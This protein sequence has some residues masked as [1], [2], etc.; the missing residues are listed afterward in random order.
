MSSVEM[1]KLLAQTNLP[2]QAIE[3][4]RKRLTV[5][6]DLVKQHNSRVAQVKA[7]KAADANN[8]ENVDAAWKLNSESDAEIDE[9]EPRFQA[10]T[11]EY[12]KVLA[13][14]RERGKLQIKAPL[15]PEEVTKTRK[16]VNDSMPGLEKARTEAETMASIVTG[17]LPDDAPDI[18]SFIPAVESMKGAGSGGGRKS[19]TSEFLQ[20]MTRVGDILIDGVSTKRD[21][22]GKFN[23]AADELSKLFKVDQFPQNQVDPEALED[24]YYASLGIPSRKK[25]ELPASHTFDF[26]FNTVVGVKDNSTMTN[27]VT[28]KVTVIPPESKAKATETVSEEKKEEKEET[29]PEANAEK[30]EEAKPQDN[31]SN[32]A[33]NTEKATPAKKTAPKATK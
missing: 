16:V 11:A 18:M 8:M 20:Y 15:S 7:A 14:L 28:H 4:I 32:S 29:T 22:K 1:D 19:T 24:A 30:V 26:T 10:I 6:L 33:E 31:A 9:L 5:L 12:E 23:F 2:E 21:G 27:E 13:Q 17:M 3:P 25:T